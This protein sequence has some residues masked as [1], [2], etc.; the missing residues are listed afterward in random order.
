MR[1]FNLGQYWVY[2]LLEQLLQLFHLFE[3]CDLVLAAEIPCQTVRCVVISDHYPFTQIFT[4]VYI[5]KK[6]G[7]FV[8]VGGTTG[9]LIKLKIK[10]DFRRGLLSFPFLAL[11]IRLKLNKTICVLSH[12]WRGVDVL[13]RW[14]SCKLIFRWGEC[15]D[16]NFVSR[17]LFLLSL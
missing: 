11:L 16:Q 2:L 13:K 7:N 15:W 17:C 10:D 6:Q 5:H 8:L 1:L 14:F 3:I 9:F 12:L 4:H